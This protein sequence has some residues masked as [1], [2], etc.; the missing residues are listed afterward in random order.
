[1][2]GRGTSCIR[3]TI[4]Q[5][6]VITTPQGYSV[7]VHTQVRAEYSVMSASSLR[8]FFTRVRERV[9]PTGA[10]FLP[11]DG[12]VSGNC[13]GSKDLDECLCKVLHHCLIELR[14][15]GLGLAALEE[16]SF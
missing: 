13:D 12:R 6:D 1:M 2:G 4:V 14:A 15:L 11:R 9:R 16:S 5:G 8:S 10:G 3:S 7:E